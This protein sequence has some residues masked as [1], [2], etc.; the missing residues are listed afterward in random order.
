MSSLEAYRK[1]GYVDENMRPVDAAKYLGISESTLAKLRM[2]HKRPNGPTF[3][4]LGGCVIYRKSDL[5]A[6]IVQNLIDGGE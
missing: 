4:R 5:D 3:G 1:Q 6:W 2:H